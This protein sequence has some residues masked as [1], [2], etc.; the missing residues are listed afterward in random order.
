V[1]I[2]VTFASIIV[3]MVASLILA[4]RPQD[5]AVVKDSELRLVDWD[6]LSY[7]TLA[8]TAHV[9]GVVVIRARLNAQGTVVAA[10]AV[11]GNEVLVPDCLANAKQWRFQPNAKN[12][13]II[14]YNFRLTGSVS[15]SGCS[16]F[17]LSPPNFATITSCVPQIQ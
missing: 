2:V 8:R 15:K 16:H 11:S 9:Q 1:K 12:T 10:E 3:L 17:E 14:V 4:Y 6:D 13:A 7:P 5:D